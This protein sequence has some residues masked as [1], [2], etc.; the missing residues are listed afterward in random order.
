MKKVLYIIILSITLCSCAKEHSDVFVPYPGNSLNDTVWVERPAA[1]APVNQITDAI[2]F[3]AKEDVIDATND[4]KARFSEFVEV[5]IP[6]RSFALQNGTVVSGNVRVE[7]VHLRTKGDMVRFSKPTT[8]FNRL[9]ESAG[10]FLIR[11][12]K[13][14]QPLVL[15]QG[16]SFKFRFRSPSTVQDTKVF[17]G[18]HSPS[19][20]FPGAFTWITANDSSSVRSFQDSLG[21]R[22]YSVTTQKLGWINCATFSDSTQ[23]KTRINAITPLNFTN[24]NTTV[25]AVFKDQKTV[26]QLT[27]D[28][29]SRTFHAVNIPLNKTITLL[30]ISRIND[31]FYL[32]SKEV[33]V[34][35]DLTSKLE[36]QKKSKQELVQFLEGL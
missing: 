32:A 15:V 11:A 1:N 22:G 24:S 14:N 28:P 23:A 16:K 35:P 29:S 20:P 13:E 18:E 26:V 33:V 2:S 12:F 10:E 25:F 7:L 19:N 9:L 36:P 31:D 6:A 8:S 5:D 21:T 3:S 27:P 4:G 17:Y 30:S 34:M